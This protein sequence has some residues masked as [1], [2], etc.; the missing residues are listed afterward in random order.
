MI[1]FHSKFVEAHKEFM[2]SK[3]D[4]VEPEYLIIIF[5]KLFAKKIK[6]N[7]RK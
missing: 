4:L 2:K 1:K 5:K 6:L 3:L 7:N